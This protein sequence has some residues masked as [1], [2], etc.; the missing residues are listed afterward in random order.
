MRPT[1]IMMSNPNPGPSFQVSPNLH[2]MSKQGFNSSNTSNTSKIRR[3]DNYQPRQRRSLCRIARATRSQNPR[4]ARSQHLSL[5]HKVRPSPKSMTSF[6]GSMIANILKLVL[7]N[8]LVPPRPSPCRYRHR[9]RVVTEIARSC[10]QRRSLE[11]ATWN[12]LLKRRQPQTHQ[13][14]FSLS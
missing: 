11:L 3:V 10:S 13:V 6:A 4:P 8:Y 12:R 1:I 2:I 7:T 9:Q 14:D 5:L